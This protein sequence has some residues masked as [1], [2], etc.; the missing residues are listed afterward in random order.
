MQ[1]QAIAGAEKSIMFGIKSNGGKYLSF[2]CQ[3]FESSREQ[4]R[5]RIK[6]P[7]VEKTAF[8]YWFAYSL[9]KSL[10]GGSEYTLPLP[11]KGTNMYILT[12]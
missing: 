1:C 11:P 5:G 4:Q 8:W 6:T 7:T 10:K 12:I 9:R 2:T 3:E